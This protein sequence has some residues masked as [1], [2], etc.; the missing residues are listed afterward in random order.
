VNKKWLPLALAASFAIGAMTANAADRPLLPVFANAAEVNAS[1]DTGMAAAQK[2]I[3]AFSAEPANAA[4]KAKLAA[5]AL[6]R[7]DALNILIEDYSGPMDI[8]AAVATDS[9]VR[10]AADACN[11]RFA[12]LGNE[13]FQNTR[14]YEQIRRVGKVSG[15]DAALRTELI[16]GFEDAGVTLPE[17]KRKL[18]REIL[19]R[20][21]V[22]AVDFQKNTREKRSTVT[23]T[24]AEMAGLPAAYLERHKPDADGR[25]TLTMDYT[26]YFPFMENA[27]SGD[28]RRRY[29]VAFT[30]VGGDQNLA[31]MAEADQ[32]RTVLAGLFGKP[33]YADYALQR[34]MAATPG[35]VLRF[36]AEVKGKV[37]EVERRELAVL[38]EA[39]AK[40]LGTAPAATKL[41]RWD[42]AFYAER[43]RRERYAVDQEALRRY[44]P[45]EASVAW[46]FDLAHRLY[47]VS[48]VATDA[49]RWHED[50]RYYD[51]VDAKGK[52]IAGAYLDLYPRPGKYN[53]AAVWPVRHGSTLAGR[54]PISVLVAN[55]DRKGLNHNELET[56]LHEFG[57]LLHGTLS[58]TRYASLSGTSVRRDFVEAPSQMFEEWARSLQPLALMRDHCKDCPVVDSELLDRLNRA[59]RFG[60]GIRY[61]RQHMLATFDMELAGPNPG[62]PLATWTK[63]EEASP[64]GHVPDTR[65]PAGFGHLLGGYAAGY[66]G[67]MWA[68]VLALDMA[69]QW[70]N[71]LLD[72]KV[73]RR[74]LDQVLSKGGEEPPQKM[75]RTFLGR[76]PSPAAFF[77][78]ITGERR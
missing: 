72:G 70:G 71:N 51:V 61:A 66:Y 37:T 33:S 17:D 54:T 14:A 40:H 53:H 44:F 11:V 1:C 22:L 21:A 20:L 32:L 13:L 75:V 3:E 10:D 67:Y 23:F 4:A 6:R 5:T 73:G 7:W 41:D 74:Y 15:P 43:V 34:R 19:D 48:F 59:R 42:T 18:A 24:A 49:P 65:F 77:A 28:A 55:L 29:F 25:Y 78:E 52:R 46:M 50:V 36:L 31:F 58:R 9:A 12:K 57:H 47:G 68:E 26:D 62:D 8:L 64:L 63:L 76:D 27:E 38:T 30:N 69:T 2:A 60:A 45:T 56:L 16:E 39:K 35:N